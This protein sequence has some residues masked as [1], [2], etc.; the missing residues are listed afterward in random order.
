[1]ATE[2]RRIH[3]VVDAEGNTI[4][5]LP[6]TSAEQVTIADTGNK[7]ESTNVE[8]ALQELAI[9]I[10]SAGKVEDVVN[11]DGTSIVDDNKKAQLK[12]AKVKEAGKVTQSLRLMGTLDGGGLTSV[13]Y[14]G[15][16]DTSITMDGDDFIMGGEA[17]ASQSVSYSLKKTGVNA[18]AYQGITVDE[19]GRV[20][21]AEDKDYVTHQELQEIEAGKT[22]TM[23]YDDYRSFVTATDA[24]S[25][26][27]MD[28]NWNVLIRTLGV[29]DMWVTRVN[30][31]STQYI[32]TSDQAIVDALNS[33][34]GLTVGYFTFS[35]LETTK[36]DLTNYQQKT[37]DGLLTDDKTVV[38]GI[39]EV[40]SKA[41][42]ALSKAIA[43]E[44]DIAHIIDGTTT[45]KKA[46]E[47]SQAVRATIADT[48]SKTANA[49]T[50]LGET[51]GKTITFDGSK[52][53]EI[54]FTG[55]FAPQK[56]ESGVFYVYLSNTGVTA[57]QY[58]AVN[59]DEAGRV[60]AGGKSVEWGASG[61]TMPSDD[62][63]VGGLFLELQS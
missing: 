29:P 14:N 40:R 35:Q 5:V 60:T 47:A 2:K 33:Q 51:G 58:S 56:D 38:G 25:K 24:L 52:S 26:T 13:A 50:F 61:Q 63:M 22:G 28:V 17:G 4:Q 23:V 6:E 16:K 59:V 32:Y 7:F 19:K 62:L 1:M 53:E 18:G 42:E 12:D 20:V 31:V 30:A 39:N 3:R 36:V 11:E 15:E 10:A 41:N 49:L 45:V 55:D 43:N 9:G 34:Y 37:D 54:H 27:A 48:A 57:G 46:D 44:T 21:A 8:G